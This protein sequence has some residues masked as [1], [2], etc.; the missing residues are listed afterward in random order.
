MKEY[1]DEKTVKIH[2]VSRGETVWSISRIYGMNINQIISTNQLLHPGQLV[3]GEALVIPT[4]EANTHGQ[5]KPF[6]E[7]QVCMAP[8]LML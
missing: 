5:V 1:L 2:V 7:L 8:Q 3:V 6:G 4:P